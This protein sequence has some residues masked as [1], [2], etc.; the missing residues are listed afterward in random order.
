MRKQQRIFPEKR[1][2]AQSAIGPEIALTVS[3]PPP[4]P[5]PPWISMPSPWK[6]AAE[7]P[8]SITVHIMTYRKLVVLSCQVLPGCRRRGAA[9]VLPG[10]AG[11][12]CCRGYLPAPHSQLWS[13]PGG[14]PGR[15]R[16]GVQRCRVRSWVS[17][18]P[19][20]N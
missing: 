8:S 3:D 19:N 2:R 6:Q 11:C 15:C 5:P 7:D 4:P 16:A 13:A 10:V 12:A 20:K 14:V 1:V 17:P 18:L 9:W